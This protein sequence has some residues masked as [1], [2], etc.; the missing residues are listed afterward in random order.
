MTRRETPERFREFARRSRDVVL[1]AA[2]TG[3]LTGIGV[4]LF[5]RVVVDGL[6]DRLLK[7]S[8]W[9]LA[10]MP[11]C[12]LVLAWLALHF[13]ARNEDA[14]TADAYLHAFHDADRPL[15]LREVP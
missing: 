13:V 8:P 15:R 5:E 1:L 11:L 3:V 2:L 14:G 7:L 9:L 6:L 4:A 12:G 10:F